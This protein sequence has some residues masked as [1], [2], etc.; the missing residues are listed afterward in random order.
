MIQ[1]YIRTTHK[2]QMHNKTL[3]GA[4]NKSFTQSKA[5]RAPGQNDAVAC[6]S[7]DG[8]VRGH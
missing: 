7:L 5:L 3:R 4:A 2:H 6:G 8:R 1:V